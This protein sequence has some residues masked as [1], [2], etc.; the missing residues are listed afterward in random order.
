MK[1]MPCREC[2]KDALFDSTYEGG[3]LYWCNSCASY[4]RTEDKKLRLV[5]VKD[6]RGTYYT[7]FAEQ[8]EPFDYFK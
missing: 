1:G 3:D 6:D 8:G 5:W 2:G 4:T 7:T